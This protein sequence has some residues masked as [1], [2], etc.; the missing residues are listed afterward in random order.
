MMLTWFLRRRIAAFERAYGYDMGYARDLL[1]ADRTAFLAFAR[2][3]GFAA[4]RRDAP[5]A[6]YFAAKIAATAAE[7]CGPC[8]QLAVTM[9]ERAGVGPGDLRA[10]LAGDTPGMSDDARLGWCFA[11]AVLAHDPACA[12]LRRQIAGAW[13]ERAA[14]SVAFAVTAGRLFPTLKYG[15]GHGVACAQLR[16]AGAAVDM[17]RA[18]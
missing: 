12:A 6:T 16:V 7:D 11:R 15:L 2:V 1:A 17:A 9:A 13:G 4:W 14:V 3:L 18:A 8:T 10:V 5:A